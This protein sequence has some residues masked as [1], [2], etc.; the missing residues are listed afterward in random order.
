MTDHL[1]NATAGFPRL[2]PGHVWL[3]GAGPGDPGLLTL[4]AL[5][6]LAEAD[7]IVHD[8][9]V[10]ER[11]LALAPQGAVLEFAGKRGGRPSPSQADI[12]D[13]LIALARAHHR[14]LRLRGGDPC[15]FGRGGEEALVLAATGIPFRIIPGVTSG[16][17]AL[18]VALIPATLRGV[19]Q[20]LILI[21]GHCGDGEDTVDWG[22]FVRTGQPIVL[23][24]GLRKLGGIAMSLMEGGADPHEPVAVIA[25]ATLAEERILI[26]EL[27]RVAAETR[28]LEFEAPAIIA[29]GAIVPVREKLFD[30]AADIPEMVG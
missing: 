17:A 19:N 4:H 25:S 10:G 3:A 14:V 8:A 27:H 7:V 30:L 26:S 6:G 28:E 2:E 5:A 24:M 23:Y 29:I 11:V 9:L 18:T 21:T 22:A 16:L 1:G 15:V 13:R 12:T 20:A